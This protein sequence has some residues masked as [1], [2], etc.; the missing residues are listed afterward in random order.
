MG[1]IPGYEQ[2]YYNPTTNRVPQA[3]LAG[4]MRFSMEEAE[5]N[6][7]PDDNRSDD[8]PSPWLAIRA[9]PMTV[10]VVP[11]TKISAAEAA[12]LKEGK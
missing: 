12:A 4:W 7:G 3:V 8:V 11:V 10:P 5:G 9:R 1:W 6:F 2:P